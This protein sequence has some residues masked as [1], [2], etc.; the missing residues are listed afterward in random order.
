MIHR[1]KGLRFKLWLMLLSTLITLIEIEQ[2]QALS[3]SS[4]NLKPSDRGSSATSSVRPTQT[5]SKKSNF[6]VLLGLYS[7]G[8]L[9]EPSILKQEV[10]DVEQWAGKRFSLAGSFIDIEDS[11]PAYN[12]PVPLELQRQ[13]GYT[14][15]INLATK[16]TAAEI[17]RGDVDHALKALAKAYASWSSQGKDRIAFI[18]PMPEMNGSWESYREDPANFKLA[19]QRIQR[20]F[21]EQGVAR[22]AVRWVFAPNGWSR[23]EHRF[24]NYYPGN[25][26]VDVVAFSAYNWGYCSASTAGQWKAWDRP[27]KVFDPYIQ[28]MRSM[29]P[30]KPIFIAQTATTSDDKTGSSQSAKDQWLRDTY[31]YLAASGVRGILYFN[32]NKECDWAFYRASGHRN[33]GYKAA[34]MNPAFGYVSPSDLAQMNLFNPTNSG[35]TRN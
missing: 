9:G 14:A 24:E 20:I 3:N 7:S 22:N 11:N 28:R 8:Y 29:A 18:A 12:I 23:N 15:F 10:Q 6:P 2:M 21:A 17:A 13:K 33:E 31:T 1:F 34:V 32:L 30:N 35:T 16:R 5:N 26:G 25:D 4:P 27:E 19:Y